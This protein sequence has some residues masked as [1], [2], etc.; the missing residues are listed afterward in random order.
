M[1]YLL[2][3]LSVIITLA[4]QTY[5]STTYSKYSQVK[6]NNNLT[7]AE[8][9]RK[10]LDNNGL[11]NI[12][13]VEVRG[14][15]SDHYD[16]TK[17]LV[18][19]SSNN[20]NSSSIAG[21]SVAAHEC[22]HAIQDKENYSFMRLRASLVPIVNLSSYAGYIAIVLGI[23]M[24]ALNFIWIGIALEVVIL[25]FQLITLP[26][27]FDA[28]KKALREVEK[29]NIL[30]NQEIKAGKTVVT[31]AALTYVASVATT[32]IEILRLIVVFGNRRD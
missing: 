13:V 12:E 11:N 20:F 3:G 27:E 25:L 29:Y 2:L 5:I 32:L 6:S 18:A 4:A 19:L 10:I 9:A 21:V 23:I 7:G 17:K 1:E 26:V 30:N 14:Y 22:G 28:S 15:L 8:V 24:G 31:S 16:P